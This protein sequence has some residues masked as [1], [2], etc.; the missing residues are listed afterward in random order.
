MSKHYAVDFTNLVSTLLPPVPDA[1]LWLAWWV[2]LRGPAPK[3]NHLN[4]REQRA[5]VRQ[6]LRLI[7]VLVLQDEHLNEKDMCV[8]TKTVLSHLGRA[9]ENLLAPNSLGS[10]HPGL[11][12]RSRPGQRNLRSR[13]RRT[14]A[15]KL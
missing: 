12:Q 7:R 6:P 4:W 1:R 13:D 14:R 5:Q 8:S 11:Q 3:L 15:L 2:A 9:E 10:P